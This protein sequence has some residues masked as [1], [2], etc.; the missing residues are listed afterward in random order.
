MIPKLELFR[1][2]TFYTAL[3][4]CLLAM[5]AGGVIGYGRSKRERSAGLRTYV[6]ISLGACMSVLISMYLAE[7]LQGPWLKIVEEVGQK[8]DAGRLGAQVLA[9]IGFLGAAIIIKGDHQ[10]VHG[11]TT[12]TGLFA[13][14][15]MGLA[16]SVGFYELVVLSLIVF[17][18]V[19]NVF[20][21]AEG[22]FKRRIRN[23]TMSVEFSTVEDLDLITQTILQQNAEI[24]DIDIEREEAKKAKNASAIYTLQLSRENHSHSSML[25]TVAELPCVI[26]VRELIA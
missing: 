19:I 16:S 11:L 22:I 20:S 2:F 13:A 25:S 15:A 26:S 21:S 23:I 14:V 10:Q 17:E 8:F 6:L 24:F 4:R 7:M 1:G 12:A 18:L 9:G 5:T 3:L